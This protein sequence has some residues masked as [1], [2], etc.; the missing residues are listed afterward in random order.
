MCLVT[1][2]IYCLNDAK[3]LK[4]IVLEDILAT[5]GVDEGRMIKEFCLRKEWFVGLGQMYTS[6]NMRASVKMLRV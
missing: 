1:L 4:E 2:D 3:S 5:K 6:S